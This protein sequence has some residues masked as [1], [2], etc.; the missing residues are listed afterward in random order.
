M[1]D[2]ATIPFG[3]WW[4][5]GGRLAL[6]YIRAAF[7][8]DF[9]C[10]TRPPGSSSHEAAVRFYNGLRADGMGYHQARWCFRG[11]VKFGPQWG[12]KPLLFN[13]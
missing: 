3:V 12:A 10:E 1:S 11:V 7:V 9:W 6:D 2:G 8:H 13:L 5:M 4:L